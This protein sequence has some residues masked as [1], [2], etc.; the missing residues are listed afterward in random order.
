VSAAVYALANIP[1]DWLDFSQQLRT[2]V[3]KVQKTLGK[4]SVE[5]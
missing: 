2:G 5:G 1:P 4:I 3:T